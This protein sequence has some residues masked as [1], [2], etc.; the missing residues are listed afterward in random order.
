MVEMLAGP[1][2]PPDTEH[3]WDWFL[4]VSAARSYTESGRAIRVSSL[5]IWAWGQL[6][7]VRLSPWHIR[8]IRALDTLCVH[9][10]NN[11][12]D[13]PFEEEEAAQ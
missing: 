10:L 8:T 4:D 5:E 3:I 1:P 13:D 7:G 11:P 9:T 2:L 12:P 6:A